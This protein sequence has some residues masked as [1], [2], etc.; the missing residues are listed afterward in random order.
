MASANR[1]RKT[2]PLAEVKGLVL[3]LAGLPSAHLLWAAINNTLG[4]NPIEKLTHVT[5][6]WAL[7][8]LIMTLAI[9]PLRKL[10]GWPW[11]MQLRRMLGLWAFF[12][13]CLHVL[14]YL[15]LDQFF[16]WAAIYK[17]IVK[18]PYITVGFLAFL[19]LIPLAVTSSSAMIK[20]IGG[21]RW[22]H[23]HR[24]VY[25]VAVA[26]VVH[27]SWL[28]KK[29]LSKPLIFATVLALLFAVRLF[30]WLRQNGPANK[31]RGQIS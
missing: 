9:T 26:G 21:K 29:D 2:L 27:Y 18:R 31:Q 10:S 16:D 30:Y 3:M 7:T 1:L 4:A 13:A 17:D 19:L 25:V 6:Y 24:L 8:L 23:L 22:R 15:I 11:L 14:T 5:G 28:V 20:R 12:Y